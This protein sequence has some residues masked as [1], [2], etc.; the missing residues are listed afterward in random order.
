[1]PI[2]IERDRF[3]NLDIYEVNLHRTEIEVTFTAD[4][5]VVLHHRFWN[6]SDR[7]K[8][9]SSAH[10]LEM[11][12]DPIDL[13]YHVVAE[14]DDGDVSINEIVEKCL[15][16]NIEREQRRE[17]FR[18]EW[19]NEYLSRDQV[20]FACIDAYCAFRIGKNIKAWRFIRWKLKVAYSE[21]F[22]TSMD[23]GLWIMD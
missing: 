23:Y 3:K 14:K 4:S 17:I 20:V 13:R 15:G 1:M 9:E 12:R 21:S 19:D 7:R 2:T 16:Y 6:N 5:T 8:L 11:C 10:R 22:T 18:S